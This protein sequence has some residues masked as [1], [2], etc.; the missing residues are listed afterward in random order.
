MINI[1]RGL[2]GRVYQIW[3]QQQTSSC[4]VACAWMAR[5][6][7]RQMSF[8]EEEWELARRIYLSSVNSA[9]TAASTIPSAPMTIAPRAYRNTPQNQLQNN[10]SSNF[11][12]AG[13]TCTQLANALRHDGLRVTMLSNNGSPTPVV[14]N[15]I[16]YNRPAISFVQWTE[17]GGAHFVVVGRCTAHHVTFLDPWTGHIRE[18]PNDGNFAASYNIGI[19]LENLYI[20]A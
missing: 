15:N 19:I 10:F 8:A 14:A 13:L 12:R 2:G 20:S 18:Q 3:K 5:G 7:A 4:G 6:I 1:E 11:S 9:L 16:A 17:S